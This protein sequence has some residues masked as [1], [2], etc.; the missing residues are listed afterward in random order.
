[1]FRKSSASV[2]FE[3]HGFCNEFVEHFC[4][5]CVRSVCLQPDI[6]QHMQTILLETFHVLRVALFTNSSV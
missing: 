1:M 2:S 4:V 3:K 6:K 5:A